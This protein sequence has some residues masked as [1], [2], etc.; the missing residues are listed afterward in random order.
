MHR[1]EEEMRAD[2]YRA[3]AIGDIDKAQDAMNL[4][5]LVGIDSLSIMAANRAA[6]PL[7][8]IDVTPPNLP[9]G[10]PGSVLHDYEPVR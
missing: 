7:A 5:L 6:K 9:I 1:R 3:V 8:D 10:T 2:L 4:M